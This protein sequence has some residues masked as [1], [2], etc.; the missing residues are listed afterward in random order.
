ML[1][2]LFERNFLHKLIHTHFMRWCIRAAVV[3]ARAQRQKHNQRYCLGSEYVYSWLAA[4]VQGCQT[5]WY[6]VGHDSGIF[7][8]IKWKYECWNFYHRNVICIPYSSTFPLALILFLTWAHFLR[9]LLAFYV[10]Y[11]SFRRSFTI[12]NTFR[13]LIKMLT[14]SF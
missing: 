3:A 8:S 12:S 4:L 7:K 5:H 6:N 2:I 13:K 10:T 9:S 1:K 14:K 11:I